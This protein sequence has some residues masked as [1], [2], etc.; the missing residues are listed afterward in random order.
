MNDPGSA[1][2]TR[3]QEIGGQRIRP[4]LALN[5]GVRYAGL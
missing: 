3:L 5:T 2:S 1:I 4:D